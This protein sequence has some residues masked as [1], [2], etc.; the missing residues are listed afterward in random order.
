MCTVEL[1]VVELLPALYTDR[2]KICEILV[3]SALSNRGQSSRAI[4]NAMLALASYHR[5]NDPMEVERL[6]GAA[7]R[8]LYTHSAPDMCHGSEHVAANLLLCVLEVFIHCCHG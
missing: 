4:R 3:Q 5:G 1:V 2:V 7:L 8:D 6:K